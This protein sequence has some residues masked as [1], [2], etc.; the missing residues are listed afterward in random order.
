MIKENAFI[1]S[2][3]MVANKVEELH[4][5]DESVKNTELL[6]RKVMKDMRMRYRKVTHIAMSANSQRSLVLR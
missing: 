3:K 2:S 5:A 6:A 1:D 4:G